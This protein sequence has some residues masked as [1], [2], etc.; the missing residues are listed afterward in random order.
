MTNQ[1]MFLFII[2]IVSFLFAIFNGTYMILK[3]NQTAQTMATIVSVTL[4]NRETVKVW[5]SKWAKVTYKVNGNTY[6]SQNRIQVPMTAQVGSL[7][8]IRYDMQ[9]PEKLYSYSMF[10]ILM[11][12]FITAVCVTVAIFRMA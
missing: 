7:V 1:V 4:S 12:L 11:A 6:N 5:N 3:R 9:H 2:A 10:K 8:K